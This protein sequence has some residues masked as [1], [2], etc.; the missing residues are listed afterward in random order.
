M[1]DAQLISQ[2]GQVESLASDGLVSVST[3][4]GQP[5]KNMELAKFA[6]SLGSSV[7]LQQT[8]EQVSITGLYARTSDG[9]MVELTKESVASVMAGLYEGYNIPINMQKF[10]SS[11]IFVNGADANDVRANAYVVN[12]T[13]TPDGYDYGF[14][15]VIWTQATGTIFQRFVSYDDSTKPVYYARSGNG[16]FWNPWNRIDNFGYNTLAELSSGVAQQMGNPVG[17]NNSVL[18]SNSNLDDIKDNGLYFTQLAR[19][20]PSEYSSY[21]GALKVEKYYGGS[22]SKHVVIQTWYNS[23]TDV[24]YY[25][26]KFTEGSWGTWQKNFG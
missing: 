10:K 26:R 5:Q 13:N 21:W 14:I 9:K 17:T 19:N 11:Y 3:G 2:A 22:E 24:T 18:G 23:L 4:A 25:T 20:Q 16:T 6:D 15:E 8:T 12:A 1:Q 7:P